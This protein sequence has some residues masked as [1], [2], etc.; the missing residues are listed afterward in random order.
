MKAV[1]LE[2]KDLV[3]VGDTLYFQPDWCYAQGTWTQLSLK[4]EHPRA[5]P[6][7]GSQGMSF[8]F[9]LFDSNLCSMQPEFFLSFRN[10]ERD[11]ERV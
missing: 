11:Q 3:G 1:R 6:R 2:M 5:H 9:L 7:H 10:D 4:P 8:P